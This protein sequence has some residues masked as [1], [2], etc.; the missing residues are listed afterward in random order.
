MIIGIVMLRKPEPMS[1]V[2]CVIGTSITTKVKVAAAM[3]FCTS[4]APRT[5]ASRGAS[6]RSMWRRITST[7]T[8]ESSSNLP[9]TKIR[10]I[11]IPK[12]FW[13]PSMWMTKNPKATAEGRIAAA[14]RVPLS[15][16]RKSSMISPAS[17]TARK[18]SN[19]AFESLRSM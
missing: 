13:N 16:P 1:P 10:P 9:T 6:P 17:A 2:I 8:M 15:S 18:N 5:A 19:R 14:I 3:A 12:S 4:S 11:V 7:T